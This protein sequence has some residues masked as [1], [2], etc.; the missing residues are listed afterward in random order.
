MVPFYWGGMSGV[1]M[2]LTL[3][4]WENVVCITPLQLK[5]NQCGGIISTAVE[6]NYLTG[7]RNRTLREEHKPYGAPAIYLYF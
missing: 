4:K 6:K 5:S 7:E 3:K 2:G 1:A